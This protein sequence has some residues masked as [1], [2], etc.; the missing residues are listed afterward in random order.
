MTFTPRQMRLHLR[1]LCTSSKLAVL[2]L[3]ITVLIPVSVAFSQQSKKNTLPQPQALNIQT[4]EFR[5][6]SSAAWSV[7]TKV[8]SQ[9]KELLTEEG[10]LVKIGTPL[11]Q[12]DDERAQLEYQAAEARYRRAFLK[13]RQASASGDEAAKGIAEAE[14]VAAGQLLRVA[15]THLDN[16]VIK[17]PVN[18]YLTEILAPVGSIAKIGDNVLNLTIEEKLHLQI[19]LSRDKVSV[20]SIVA[21]TI[22]TQ[23]FDAKVIALDP[24]IEEHARLKTIVE[25]IA[26]ATLEVP[27]AR[28]QL[29]RGDTV[30]VP[31]YPFVLIPRQAVA[32]S[33]EG[34]TSIYVTRKNTPTALPVDVVSAIDGGLLVAAAPLKT[35]DVILAAP[36]EGE[37]VSPSPL[38]GTVVFPPTDAA[39]DVAA[40]KTELP[41][42]SR[43]LQT[44]I[45][46]GQEQSSNE[47]VP[48]IEIDVPQELR[49][50]L[51]NVDFPL[52]EMK[53]EKLNST[54]NLM[55][56]QMIAFE[57]LKAEFNE[58]V[59]K[60]GLKI[61]SLDDL[62][63]AKN[64]E[65][66]IQLAQ[67]IRTL[68]LEFADE[69]VAELDEDQTQKLQPQLDAHF[70][71]AKLSDAKKLASLNLT[72]EQQ[73]QIENTMS[74][75]DGE[76][77]QVI[78]DLSKKNITNKEGRQRIY[79]L[80]EEQSKDE[81]AFLPESL[82]AAML[83]TESDAATS[84]SGGKEKGN[85][86][87]VSKSEN[88]NQPKESSEDRA[89]RVAQEQEE[90]RKQALANLRKQ[91]SENTA[92]SG[93]DIDYGFY[94][95]IAGAVLIV[96]GAIAY[97]SG[98]FRK[99]T[100][101]PEKASTD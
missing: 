72:D 26:T 101:E 43:N 50:I 46:A 6:E 91:N 55:P 93:G 53:L 16:H 88:S 5:L 20:G 66:F 45:E 33:Q 67:K 9:V 79:K 94:A 99:K 64:A 82:L 36:V 81:L 23:L 73:A 84:S 63:D 62:K 61:N 78:Q 37:Q 77:F 80:I 2:C 41:D 35:D 25:D 90:A 18:G 52:P 44:Y 69:L 17:A 48:V 100:G 65:D 24:P 54:L 42:Y 13:Y 95:L 58:R 19:P 49:G 51:Q 96:L 87:K 57:E 4:L 3:M 86:A 22:G 98:V 89:K 21:I 59:E 34:E 76:R 30:L 60:Q 15:K 38:A 7:R 39:L 11:V 68:N 28:H 1:E 74:E 85:S 56:D 40:L 14:K 70:G 71:L 83:K 31:Q 97:F 10:S 47:T 75:I 12:L 27:N 92:S 32:V 8:L 29:R